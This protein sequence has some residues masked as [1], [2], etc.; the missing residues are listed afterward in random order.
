MGAAGKRALYL[1][2]LAAAVEAAGLVLLR[3]GGRRRGRLDAGTFSWDGVLLR[4]LGALLR[5][6]AALGPRMWRPSG[7]LKAGGTAG[8][9]RRADPGRRKGQHRSDRRPVTAPE[10]AGHR[11]LD[12]L[13]DYYAKYLP[14]LVACA[15]GAPAGGPAS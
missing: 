3:L 13:D 12:G 7:P 15:I 8:P 14:A 5:S 2:G 11:G 6:A 10:R 9:P 1:L 4:A